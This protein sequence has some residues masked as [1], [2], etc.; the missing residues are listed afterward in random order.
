MSMACFEA[1]DGAVQLGKQHRVVQYLKS[2]RQRAPVGPKKAA[3]RGVLQAFLLPIGL[4]SGP[5]PPGLCRRGSR[6]CRRDLRPVLSQ[7]FEGATFSFSLSMFFWP[8]ASGFS[9]KVASAPPP[10]EK[11]IALRG[12]SAGA[13]APDPAGASPRTPKICP[14]GQ[15]KTGLAPQTPLVEPSPP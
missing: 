14:A 10:F 5:T 12:N 8:P 15:K 6:L 11:K 2:V 3:A 4:G 1:T 13:A 7:V 9:R